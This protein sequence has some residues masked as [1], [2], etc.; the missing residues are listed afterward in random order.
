MRDSRGWK[1][2][3]GWGCLFFS[4]KTYLVECKFVIIGNDDEVFCFWCDG[5]LS[6]WEEEDIPLVE[7][8]KFFPECEY[9]KQIN[10]EKIVGGEASPSRTSED[11]RY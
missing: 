10:I 9:I 2:A 5:T 7:H 11:V 8:A 6:C 3:A 1:L 4:L